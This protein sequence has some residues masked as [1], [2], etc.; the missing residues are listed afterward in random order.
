[1]F[2][3]KKHNLSRPSVSTLTLSW[4]LKGVLD[5]FHSGNRVGG[6]LIEYLY[7]KRR[8]GRIYELL[9]NRETLQRAG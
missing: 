5:G 3:N 2:S 8:N 4:S 7:D 6:K 1:M 9:G